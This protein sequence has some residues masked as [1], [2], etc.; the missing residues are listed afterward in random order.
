MSARTVA[1]AGRLK[2][3]IV[4]P[5]NKQQSLQGAIRQVPLFADYYLPLHPDALRTQPDAKVLRGQLLGVQGA[6]AVH[7]PTSGQLAGFQQRS[8]C[9]ESGIVQPH[10]VLKSDGADRYRALEPW[11]Q[12][13]ERARVNERILN[14][15]VGGLGGSGFPTHIKLD[16]RAGQIHTLL[17]NAAECEPY[18]SADDA[19]LRER[20][21]TVL[22]GAQLVAQLCEISRCVVGIEINKPEAIAA[23]HEAAE[24]MADYSLE[25]CELPAVYPGGGEKQIIQSVLN[26]KVPSGSLPR[27][28]GVLCLNVGTCTALAEA[29]Y[30]DRP[31]TSR[32]TTLTGGALAHP[33]NV[34]ARIGTAVADLLDFAGLQQ[35]RLERVL[36][37][38]PMMGITLPDTGAS[39]SRASNCLLAAEHGEL[40]LPQP[41]LPCI[42]C[43]FCV[44][45]CPVDLLPQ[46]LLAFAKTSQY[47]R[48]QTHNLFDCIECGACAAVCPSNIPLVGYYR[49]AKAEIRS[50]QSRTIA[51]DRA[52]LRFEAHQQ[53]VQEQQQAR[54]QERRARAEQ[55]RKKRTGQEDE[56]RAAQERL[57]K[58]SEKQ[59][60][61]YRLSLE[62]AEARLRQLQQR[63][64]E[65]PDDESIAQELQ[66]VRAQVQ[67]IRAKAEQSA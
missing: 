25:I 13:P 40:G 53:R 27:D 43:G 51:S 5:E 14:S 63:A 35:E 44:H 7:A 19:L 4:L 56:V 52:R 3:G 23:L 30:Q 42:R 41:E 22:R 62:R 15:G 12:L 66:L 34:E 17:L 36:V 59:Q 28:I 33:G 6:V 31:L 50:E 64:S 58:P 65:S 54:E 8:T 10:L 24:T 48:L 46:Q 16:V 29:V 18:I 2:K 45:A 26:L 21:Q 67:N 39:I 61:R 38:G 37:G 55:R 47:Q 32:I 20:A 11:E 49:A 1:A 57:A 60:Q 9:H